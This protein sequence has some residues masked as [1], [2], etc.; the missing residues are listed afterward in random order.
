MKKG[1]SMKKIC[2][3][4]QELLA[5]EGV[6]ALHQ[7]PQARDHVTDCSDCFPFLEALAAIEAE[8]SA[9]PP[10]Q[11]PQDLVERV[12]ASA[13]SAPCV[14]GEAE[15]DRRWLGALKEAVGTLTRSRPVQ[16]SLGVAG[17]AAML[18]FVTPRL[19]ER[20]KLALDGVSE[21]YVSVAVESAEQAVRRSA[22]KVKA[23]SSSVPE[24][25]LEELRALGYVGDE[26]AIVEGERNYEEDRE[27]GRNIALS[28]DIRAAQK[29]GSVPEAEGQPRTD[30]GALGGALAFGEDPDGVESKQLSLPD[31]E[32]A[33]DGN[34][35]ADDLSFVETPPSLVETFPSLGETVIVT[36][37]ALERSEASSSAAAVL[38]ESVPPDERF[39]KRDVYLPRGVDSFRGDQA[40]RPGEELADKKEDSRMNGP[41]N[42]RADA[43]SSA[44]RFLAGRESTANLSFQEAAGYWANTYVP[45]DPLL[46]LLESRVTGEDRSELRS[47]LGRPL[48]L[49]NAARQ[50]TQ[51][52]DPPTAAALAAYLHADRSGLEQEGRVLLQVGLQ[53]TTRSSGRRGPMNLCLVLDLRSELD[54][55]AVTAMR[56]LVSSLG[57]ARDLGDRFCLVA[58]GRPGGVIV[59]PGQ[60]HYGPLRVAMDRLLLERGGDGEA[61]DPVRALETAIERVA[62][63]DDPS[64]PLG[65][66]VVLLATSQ[67]FGAA[68]ETLEKLA[69]VSAVAGV[70]VGVVGIGDGVDTKE[71]D[72]IALAG[73]GNRR[74][75]QSAA[76]ADALVERELEAVSRVVARAVRLRIRLAPGVRLIEVVGS[77]RLGESGAARVR[78]AEES[79][80]RRLAKN[81]GITADRGDDEDGIQIVIPSFYAG[82]AH[83]FLLDV[84]A[85][86]AGEIADVTVRYKDLVYLRNGVSRSHLDLA[87]QQRPAGALE[88]NVF[89]NL[90]A[91][92]LF[93]TLDLAGREVAE[94][95]PEH[96]GQTLERAR[97]LLQGLRG[98]VPGLERDRDIVADLAMLDE[99]LAVLAARPSVL[100][101]WQ[102]QLS[103]SLRYAGHLKVLPRPALA[104]GDSR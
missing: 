16:L 1:L 72:R 57:A 9:L 73:Q 86:G 54:S 92:E 32:R 20:N 93:T 76:E 61:L 23:P 94:G 34:T 66:S 39:M 17:F 5:A 24:D 74:L 36:A 104:I 98:E 15:G 53:A 47:V 69:H 60:F 80:D 62:A 79:V 84:V 77:E 102:I 41:F 68:G 100:P 14:E 30:V 59:E 46:R 103:E 101:L 96:A 88:T 97:L 90:L 85:P 3:Q 26:P 95:R 27:G 4:T 45:G 13:T 55:E 12:V 25:A 7:N 82:D 33:R 11:A 83:V 99:Y 89:K 19:F 38:P 70:P 10:Y 21:G 78:E 43:T 37:E 18:F 48:Q 35:H 71:L 2:Q 50:T 52:F 51:P 28:K 29:A 63:S 58:A 44:V 42:N 65:S 6:A 49:H 8:L 91:H 64:S 56:A 75:L 81:L 67:P 87:R 22:G 31:Q 40:H